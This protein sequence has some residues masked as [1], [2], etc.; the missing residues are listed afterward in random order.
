MIAMNHTLG[1]RRKRVAITLQ[2]KTTGKSKVMLF[3]KEDSSIFFN[4]LL[5]E[6][7]YAIWVI[8]YR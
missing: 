3:Y 4:G 6:K 1:D 5:V 2:V 8:I 7:L